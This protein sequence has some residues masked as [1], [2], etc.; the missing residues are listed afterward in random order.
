MSDVK[1]NLREEIRTKNMWQLMAKLTPVAVLAM[2]INSI[3]TFVD[4]LFI[5]QFLGEKA[6]AA[7]SLAFPLAFLTNSFAAM[8]GVGG[9]SILSIAIGAKDE[10]IQKK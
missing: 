3:N 6:L 2:S 5:G 10:E 1:L 4:A 7:V 8:L 9:S